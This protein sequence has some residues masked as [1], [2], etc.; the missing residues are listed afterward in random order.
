MRSHY[1]CF[2]ELCYP[3]FTLATEGTET[4]EKLIGSVVSVPSVPSVAKAV[5]VSSI[6]SE[7]NRLVSL[8]K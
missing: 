4:T 6:L 8:S 7:Q 5:L 2:A 3:D 1:D